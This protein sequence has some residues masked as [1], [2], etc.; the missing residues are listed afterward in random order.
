MA[1][2]K[3]KAIRDVLTVVDLTGRT[4]A[5]DYAIDLAGKAEAHLT[6]IAP[7]FDYLTPSI[8]GGGLP[9]S[10]MA[11]I[12]ANAEKPAS[13]GLEAFKRRATAAGVAFETA[14][15]DAG[16]GLYDDLAARARLCDLAIVGQ[17]DP[18]HPD[19]DRRTV[20]ETLL[21]S[22]GAPT[23]VVPYIGDGRHRGARIAVAWDGGRPASRA[24]R[25]AMAL[26]AAA[27]TV[28]VIVVDDGRRFVG[29]PG[30]DL[31]LFLARHDLPVTIMR[32]PPVSGDVASAMLNIVSDEGFDMLV[33]G[34]YGHSRF[35][36]FVLGGTTRDILETMT[37]PVLMAH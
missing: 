28:S 34:A 6:G 33:M 11:E 31:A 14:R 1:Q 5:T 22:A 26:L 7:V 27:E 32:V 13:E 37:V 24:I 2:T 19:G 30:A 3:L 21:F 29:E 15:F 17:E 12:R 36:E 20:I 10:L 35:R 8:I 18:D 23:L 16:E 9:T 4:A 25:G